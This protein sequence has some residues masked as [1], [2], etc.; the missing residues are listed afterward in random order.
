SSGGNVQVA[1]VI[2][3]ITSTIANLAA[4]ATTIIINGYG[5]DSG[6]PGNNV[7]TFNDGAV[8]TVTAASATQMTVT[9]GTKPSLPGSLTATVTTDTVDDAGPVQVA[10]VIPV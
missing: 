8:G 5:F 2:P 3:V 4:N 1:T 6:T 7:V 9:F 10:T